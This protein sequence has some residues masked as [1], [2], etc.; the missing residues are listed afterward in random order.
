MH[1]TQQNTFLYIFYETLRQALNNTSWHN[2]IFV[3]GD[4]N[5]KVWSN[6]EG[7]DGIMGIHVLN[8][9]RNDNG[10][11]LISCCLINNLAIAFTILIFLMSAIFISISRS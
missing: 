5:A 4:F 2:I 9:Q 6:I 8:A 7:E 1:M 11:Q 3:I 10:E